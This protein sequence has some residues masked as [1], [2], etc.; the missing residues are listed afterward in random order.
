MGRGVHKTL[1]L[2][3]TLAVLPGSVRVRIITLSPIGESSSRAPRAE[4]R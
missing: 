3:F 4:I 1:E 2:S